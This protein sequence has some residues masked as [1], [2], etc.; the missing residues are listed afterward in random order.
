MFV[1]T[2]LQKSYLTYPKKQK[3]LDTHPVPSCISVLDSIPFSLLP[4]FDFHN[5]LTLTIETPSCT[6]T[7]IQTTNY[8]KN[9]HGYHQEEEH[10]QPTWRNL[11][12]T[13][14]HAHAH[15]S[16]NLLMHL[17]CLS[18]LHILAQ[19]VLDGILNSYYIPGS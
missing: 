14:A 19:N 6:Y 8:F 15:A 7:D 13:Y 4:T 5:T 16:L 17:E 9:H 11:C 1:S 2:L 3:G 18:S 10:L 12:V